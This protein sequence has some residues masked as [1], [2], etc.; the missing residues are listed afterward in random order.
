MLNSQQSMVPPNDPYAPLRVFADM[1]KAFA[2]PAAFQSRMEKLIAAESSANAA[3]AKAAKDTAAAQKL[4]VDVNA[5]LAAA[6]EKHNAALEAERTEHEAAME[7][8]RGEVAAL[9]AS[10]VEH[11][12][13]ASAARAEAERGKAEAQRRLRAMEG[14]L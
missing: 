13:A 4:R 2:D 5:E 10:A 7:R 8:E 1:A 3:I 9:K 14:V 12:R 6:R 11:D